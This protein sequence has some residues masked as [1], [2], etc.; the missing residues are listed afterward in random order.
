ME[1][2]GLCAN[3]RA[4]QRRGI[5]RAYGRGVLVLLALLLLASPADAAW[6]WPAEGPVVRAFSYDARAPFA[7]GARRG[8]VIGAARGSPVRA[9]CSGRVRF[10]GGAGA[11]GRTVTV[12]CGAYATTYLELSSIGVREGA[13]VRRGA[14][15]GRAG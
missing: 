3:A 12:A 5:S 11:N 8:I 7:R 13:T 9:A 14:R 4:E 10:A 15:L 1:V 6:S 2:R